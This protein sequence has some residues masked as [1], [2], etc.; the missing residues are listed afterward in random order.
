MAVGNVHW[1]FWHQS[2]LV[3]FEKVFVVPYAAGG[4]YAVT[5]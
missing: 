1:R 4:S 3:T 5:R 2:N